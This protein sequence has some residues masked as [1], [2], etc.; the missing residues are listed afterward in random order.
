MQIQIQIQIQTLQQKP[1]VINA[2][3][4]LLRVDDVEVNDCVHTHR[5]RV[6][7]QNL[8]P[9]ENV[10]K[11]ICICIC[12]SFCINFRS[13]VSIRLCVVGPAMLRGLKKTFPFL[14]FFTKRGQCHLLFT[15]GLP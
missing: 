7:R 15:G 9:E 10:R 11:F 8:E 2:A 3:E 6:P 1:E 4:R 5:H 14:P 13:F 12:P